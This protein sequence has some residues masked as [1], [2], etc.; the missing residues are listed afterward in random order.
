[1]LAKEELKYERSSDCLSQNG[2]VQQ[3]TGDKKSRRTGQIQN[4]PND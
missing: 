3:Q 2:K 4:A 1:M